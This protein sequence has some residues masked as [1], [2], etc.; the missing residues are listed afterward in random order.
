MIIIPKFHKLIRLNNHVTI[1]SFLQFKKSVLVLGP[2][3]KSYER[4][5]R[6]QDYQLNDAY[7]FTVVCTYL[8]SFVFG[9]WSIGKWLK[10]SYIFTES[11]LDYVRLTFSGWDWATRTRSSAAL[12]KKNIE[13]EI[14]ELLEEE[15]FQSDRLN[16]DKTNKLNRLRT[17][18]MMLSVIIIIADCVL[19]YYSKVYKEYPMNAYQLAMVV[20]LIVDVSYFIFGAIAKYEKYSKHTELLLAVLRNVCTYYASLY[21]LIFC[22]VQKS[23][24]DCCWED[25]I[26]EQMY[27]LLITSILSE[28]AFVLY[29]LLTRLK[30]KYVVQYPELKVEKQAAHV[31]KLQ[32]ISWIGIL[33]APLIPLVT[34][35][36]L[37]VVIVAN[38]INIF[39]LELKPKQVFRVIR[40]KFQFLVAVQVGLWLDILICLYILFFKDP[41]DSCTPYRNDPTPFRSTSIFKLI[42]PNI[43]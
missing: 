26:G 9:V 29:T 18:L 36:P 25:D 31:I 37:F 3:K 43:R 22:L 20:W 39:A 24:K 2:Y 13:K 38:C 14:L 41:S 33:W 17:L 8:I 27:A 12:G 1:I 11:D 23:K 16:A 4:N 42:T 40:A 30:A 15:K 35:V 21:I 10:S 7:F 28:L 19:V 34:L 32:A 6:G 5:H